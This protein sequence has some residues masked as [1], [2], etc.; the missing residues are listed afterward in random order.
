MATETVHA[1]SQSRTGGCAAH[2]VEH[3]AGKAIS[4][5]LQFNQA[6]GHENYGY[7]QEYGTTCWELDALEPSVIAAL[8]KDAVL[9]LRDE[10][11]WKKAVRQ[12]QADKRE[13]AEIAEN[14]G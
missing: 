14:L 4:P 12:D 7:E 1:L 6:D 13:L 10:K 2:R 8:I 3:G 11:L 5:A 9:K